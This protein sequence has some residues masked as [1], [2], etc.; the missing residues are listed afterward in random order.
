VTKTTMLENTHPALRAAWHPVARAD[1]VGAEPVAVR[2]MGEYWVVVR[3]GGEL[4]AFPDR[5]PHR[6]APLS[7][8]WVDGDVLRCGYHGWCFDAAGACTEIPALGPGATLPPRARLT[9]AAGVTERYGLVWLAL[10]PPR[11]DLPEVPEFGAEGFLIG[12]VEPMRASVGAGLMADNF[13]DVAHFPFL[14]AATIGTDESLTVDDMEITRDGFDLT[15]VLEHRFAN[16]EDPAVATGERPLV[17]RR[18]MTT[19]YR[20]PFGVRL[21]VDYL[22]AGGVNAITYFVQPEDDETCRIYACIMRDDLDGDLARLEQAVKYEQQIFDEDIALQ[23]Q[24][25]DKVLPLD[26]ATEVHVKADKMTVELRRILADFVA[27]AP[28]DASPERAERAQET[29]AS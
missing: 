19:T 24:Y 9:P 15:I 5:C 2:L 7:A 13:L 11:L 28:Q 22:D 14:H 4:A 17:Q 1:E 23:Q 25:V 3:L 12:H 21:R 8:G 27:S 18:R 29:H 6:L 26:L 10:E 20:P 16:H